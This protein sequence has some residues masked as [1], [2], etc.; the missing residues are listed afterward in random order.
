MTNID[1]IPSHFINKAGIANRLSISRV[2]VDRALTKI[3]KDPILH[4]RLKVH[5]VSE[6]KRTLYF[7]DPSDVDAVFGELQRSNK[8]RSK[9][10]RN[11][12]RKVTT[13][14]T[15]QSTALL[16]KDVQ[17]LQNLLAK[18]DSEIADLKD[19]REKKD[20]QIEFLQAQLTDQRPNSTSTPSEA[21]EEVVVPP[22]P[23]TVAEPKP[24][25]VIDFRNALE[26][27][28]AKS[29]KARE[30][31]DGVTQEG[32]PRDGII[33]IVD[34]RLKV[35]TA[36]SFENDLPDTHTDKVWIVCHSDKR[37]DGGETILGAI[38]IEA[39]YPD[40]M[41]LDMILQNGLKKDVVLTPALRSPGTAYK[42]WNGA[43]DCYDLL[44]DETHD[45]FKDNPPQIEPSEIKEAV[46]DVD[47][48]NVGRKQ[49]EIDE[50]NE[51]CNKISS[52]TYSDSLEE[53]VETQRIWNFIS[54]DKESFPPNIVTRWSNRARATRVVCL[55]DL[56]ET[57][58]GE[59]KVGKNHDLFKRL[60]KDDIDRRADE[61]P[62]IYMVDP[63]RID[64]P[65]PDH[66]QKEIDI[67][68]EKLA[69]GKADVSSTDAEPEEQP[70]S[71]PIEDTQ[72]T[73][74]AP[75]EKEAR[76]DNIAPKA[77]PQQVQKK[78]FW[79]WLKGY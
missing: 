33:S 19:Q 16:E 71:P 78:G 74:E 55:V 23:A 59:M 79:N 20:R 27:A 47:K 41:L 9:T 67:E 17:H 21:T 3:A 31:G 45:Y 66:V 70:E 51:L 24:S 7:Y 1:D 43:V 52:G 42:L 14:S 54:V 2:T 6:G 75:K 40:D 18:A 53:A 10:V 72:P 5:I 37:E 62:Y 29:N 13:T 36:M 28:R 8:G 30:Y 64:P 34:C 50:Y 38:N 44:D 61:E 69:K 63:V 58:S 25:N 46:A 35:S 4:S 76:R 12:N 60:V 56:T 26:D 22:K 48:S 68:R 15:S 39:P 11:I 65:F 77:E 73:E 57:A 49:T 32:R